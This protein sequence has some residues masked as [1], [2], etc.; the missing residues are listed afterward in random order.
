[1]TPQTRS[2]PP[3]T[4]FGMSW[5]R[6]TDAGRLIGWQSGAFKVEAHDP[7]IG[8]APEQRFRR[9]RLVAN[10]TRFLILPD[11]RPRNPASRALSLSLRRLSSDMEVLG[12]PARPAAFASDGA[13]VVGGPPEG[14]SP[15]RVGM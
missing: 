5:R 15:D 2:Q 3:R 4:G 13:G 12:H 10:N 9:L 14:A 11:A 1:M 6:R 7:W 8:W